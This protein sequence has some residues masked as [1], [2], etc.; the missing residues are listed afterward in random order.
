MEWL[1]DE[2]IDKWIDGLI[3]MMDRRVDWGKDLSMNGTEELI[4]WL[5]NQLLNSKM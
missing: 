4:D 2:R 5:L 1:M 3:I